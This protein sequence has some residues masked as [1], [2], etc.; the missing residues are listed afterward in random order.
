MKRTLARLGWLPLIATGAVFVCVYVAWVAAYWQ[1]GRR[2]MPSMDDPKFI[3]GA[4]T[5]VYD[6]AGWVILASLVMWVVGMIAAA[7][8][9]LLPRTE[10]RR[11]WTLQFVGGF[12]M[13]V[14]CLLFVRYSPGDACSWFLD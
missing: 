5:A 1:L 2:P 12:S 10:N 7:V 13:I 14:L 4:A 9:T 3:G 11:S 8:M 6:V